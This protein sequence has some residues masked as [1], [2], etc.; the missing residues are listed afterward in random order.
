MKKLLALILSLAML[1]TLAACSKQNADDPAV[2]SG[3]AAY[4]PPKTVTMIVPYAAGGAVDLAARLFAKYA[5]NYTETEIVIN[6]VSGGGG[7][8]GAA[9]LLKYPAD[10]TYLAAMNPSPGYVP[11]PDK[12]ISFDFMDDFDELAIVMQDQRV[13][14]VPKDN[15]L[16]ADFDEFMSY[17]KANPGA[18]TVG[19]SGTA[20][21]AYLTPYLLAQKAGVELTVV[22]YDGAA[23]AKADLL[24]GHISAI[25]VSYSEVLPMLQNDQVIVLCVAAEERY[26][27]LPDVPTMKEKGYEVIFSTNRGYCAK[28]GTAPEVIAYWSDIFGKVCADEGYLAEAESMGF[29]IKY[30]DAAAAE[31]LA[32][33]VMTQYKALFDEIYK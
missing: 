21:D 3:D 8:V 24:G 30:Y 13:I 25:S 20:N 14:A 33:S 10:G 23:D 9:E 29:P 18:V 5:A 7:T 11:T 16:Y 28:A 32:G 19:C 26:E 12:P 17:V 6:N 1:L 2:P 31:E 15:G 4:T 22:P 27:K